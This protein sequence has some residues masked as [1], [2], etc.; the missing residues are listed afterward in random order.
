LALN[1]IHLA[2]DEYTRGTGWCVQPPLLAVYSRRAKWNYSRTSSLVYFP[3]ACGPRHAAYNRIIGLFGRRRSGDAE[4][5]E[6]D[7]TLHA[8][9]VSERLS[10]GGHGGTC[11]MGML[12][13]LAPH[14]QS[15]AQ[16]VHRAL[17][18]PGIALG[19]FSALSRFSP[20]Q[21]ENV[22]RLRTLCQGLSRRLHLHRQAAS[23]RA[24]G[25]SNNKLHDRLWEVHVLCHLHGELSR[26]LHLHGLIVRSELLQPGGVPRRF[27]AASGRG[28]M[29]A[30]DTQPHGSG[31][32]E[33]R[34]PT[35]PRRP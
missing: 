15:A 18:V 23:G 26:Q 1:N 6:Q 19:G 25:F 24:K 11:P 8:K 35:G 10:G 14:I 12:A 17:R 7:E 34:C 16:D 28:C 3:V 27:R 29:G 21:P 31:P 5:S 13:I 4:S 32:L 20:L 30:C 9:L 22:Y 33:S 2:P